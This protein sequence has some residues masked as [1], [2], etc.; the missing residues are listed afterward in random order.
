MTNPRCCALSMG[1]NWFDCHSDKSGAN[2]KATLKTRLSFLPLKK[3]SS[4]V[5]LPVSF[6]NSNSFCF[7]WS[8]I[9]YNSIIS[10][11]FWI[12]LILFKIS[13]IKKSNEKEKFFL[14]WFQKGHFWIEIILCAA[15]CHEDFFILPRRDFKIGKA[16][17]LNYWAIV[18]ISERKFV[19]H[20]FLWQNSQFVDKFNYMWKLN[21][22]FIIIAWLKWPGHYSADATK[23]RARIIRVNIHYIISSVWVEIY[24]NISLI[25]KIKILS[26]QVSL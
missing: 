18:E 15:I 17:Q 21:Y 3:Y 22:S 4:S 14:M 20:P 26:V 5:S 7:I 19:W 25:I 11:T 10:I 6:S 16:T 2:K 24:S 23:L 8:L 1:F 13:A 9:K 12:N